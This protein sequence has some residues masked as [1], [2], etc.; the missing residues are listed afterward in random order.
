MSLMLTGP[1]RVDR[2]TTRIVEGIRWWPFDMMSSGVVSP[3]GNWLVGINEM[4]P[5]GEEA[6]Y[7]VCTHFV[8]IL[9]LIVRRH[10]LSLLI[11]HN[12]L[13]CVL[14]SAIKWCYDASEHG[15][16]GSKVVCT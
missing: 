13:P 11:A 4:S 2:S 10:L 15:R 14:F 8:S 1:S 16:R 3:L 12:H 7:M 5:K 9:Y 6:V